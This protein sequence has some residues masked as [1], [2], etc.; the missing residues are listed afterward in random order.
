MLEVGDVVEVIDELIEG[1]V[2]KITP[3]QVYI[4]TNEGIT[5]AFSANE[6]IKIDKDSPIS[7]KMTNFLPKED[8]RNKN[9]LLKGKKAKKKAIPPMEVDL[10]IEK[11]VVS[12]HGMSSYDM[13]NKQLEVAK[14]QLEFAIEK[15]IPRVV[16]I[17]GVGEG[18]LKA[19]LETLFSRY[20]NLSYQDADYARY[21]IGATEVFL[22]T[23]F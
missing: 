3:Q 4:E 19:E 22:Q 9:Y 14:H 13:L 20:K 21:G 6:L 11:L 15:R 17:H 5:L 12:T 7:Y 8:K 16:F 1:I 10:H 23:I 2:T 18:V